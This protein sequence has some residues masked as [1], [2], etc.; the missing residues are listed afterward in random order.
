MVWLW[1]CALLSQPS[2]SYQPLMEPFVPVPAMSVPQLSASAF[3]PQFQYFLLWLWLI[4]ST[5]PTFSLRGCFTEKWEVKMPAYVKIASGVR[6][7]KCGWVW[8][9]L[10]V[11]LGMEGGRMTSTI[12][13]ESRMERVWGYGLTQHV[14]PQSPII[15]KWSGALTCYCW[16]L[17]LSHHPWHFLQPAHRCSGATHDIVQNMWCQLFNQLCHSSTGCLFPHK[18]QTYL[19]MCILGRADSMQDQVPASSFL[20]PYSWILLSSH[21]MLHFSRE[22]TNQK[23]GEKKKR[24]RGRM[25]CRGWHNL[26]FEIASS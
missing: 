24:Q 6:V 8:S 2:Q 1:S 14:P 15:Q 18:V 17:A 4:H 25:E 7:W 23:K 12:P 20:Y 26:Y 3:P 13:A 11:C 10:T 16:G 21:I 19:K 9:L 5:V 22:K